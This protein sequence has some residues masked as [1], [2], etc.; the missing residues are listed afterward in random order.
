[1]HVVLLS[2]TQKSEID[3]LGATYFPLRLNFFSDLHQNDNIRI[4]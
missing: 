3:K 4:V 2:H 1:M